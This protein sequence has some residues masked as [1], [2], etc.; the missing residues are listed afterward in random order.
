[1]KTQDSSIGPGYETRI[2]M[3]ETRTE[4][5]E[6]RSERAEARWEQAEARSEQAELRTELVGVQSEQALVSLGSSVS[7]GFEG[8]RRHLIPDERP[9][10]PAMQT[11]RRIGSF[12]R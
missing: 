8:R 5:A 12:P 4:Q 9:D 2:E 3:A 6:A 10:G 7:T 11:S 1:M